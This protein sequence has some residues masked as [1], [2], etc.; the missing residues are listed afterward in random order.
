M[1]SD[2]YVVDALRLKNYLVD[3]FISVGVP[4]KD[5]ETTSDV[6]VQADLRGIESHGVARILRYVGRIRDG[7][8]EPRPNIRVVSETISTL[9]IDG[10]NGL[11]QVVGVYAMERCIEKAKRAGICFATVRNSNHY[12]IAGYYAMMGLKED[13]IGFSST[14]SYPLVAPTYGRK[15]MFGT[16]PIA[17]AVPTMKEVPFVLDMATTVVPLGKI[18]VSE[19]REKQVPT[20][21]GVDSEGQDTTDPSKIRNG[22]SILPLGGTVEH[23]GYKGYGLGVLV[24]ILTGVLSGGIF[25][26]DVGRPEDPM[27]SRIGHFFGA[28]NVEAFMP[29]DEFKERMDSMLQGLK[30]SPKAQGLNRIYYAGEIEAETEK[31]RLVEGI[32]IHWK[33][34]ETLK[35]LGDET[36][37]KMNILKAN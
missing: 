6:L 16:N 1:S 30:Q 15:R 17:I 23:A 29:K 33:V 9:L 35:K 31:L 22:G 34:Y 14:N 13:M 10:G 21:W 8:T 7:Q 26:P 3:I 2:E 32:P 5:A 36:G 4:K 18:E 25:G 27:P 24:D 12:G 19:R 28:M 37:V 20:G 11:G